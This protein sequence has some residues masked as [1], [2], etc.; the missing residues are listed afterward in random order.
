V[1]ALARRPPLLA[2]L[3]AAALAAVVA[4]TIIALVGGGTSFNYGDPFD[5]FPSGGARGTDTRVAGAPDTQRELRQF[6]PFVVG[7]I[8]DFWRREFERSGARYE[9]AKVVVFRRALPSGC[10]IA[11]A[12]T[13]PFYCTL[14]RSVYLELGFFDELRARFHAPGD[15]AEAYVVA[16]ELGH[17][18]QN[19]TGISAQVQRAMQDGLERPNELSIRLEL[20]ADCLAGVWAY[21]TYERG[22]LENGDLDE[23]LRAAAAV[24]DDRIQSQT[25]GRIDPETWTHGSSAQRRDWFERGFEG[26]DPNAC[27]TFSGSM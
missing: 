19:L 5:P 3:L 7:D 20:Q 18:V 17:H 1:R 12:A 4:I 2:G 9:P 25:T 10:G 16:H 22:L 11:S 8:Q 15:F 24:G 6:L 13:G 14:D 23:A 26:G 27:D 21:S